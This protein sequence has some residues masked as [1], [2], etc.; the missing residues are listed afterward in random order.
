MDRQVTIST[1]PGWTMDGQSSVATPICVSAES[2]VVPGPVIYVY[3]H[4]KWRVALVIE[5][6][7]ERSNR[8]AAP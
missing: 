8:V 5:S 7:V 6:N 1:S 4:L 3:S 2:A